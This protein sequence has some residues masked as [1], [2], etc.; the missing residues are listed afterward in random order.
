MDI[1]LQ[2]IS[3]LVSIA[4]LSLGGFVSKIAFGY[5]KSMLLDTILYIFAIILL[6]NASFDNV[7]FG[8]F[9]YFIVGFLTILTIR[10]ITTLFGLV[11]KRIKDEESIKI[12]ESR[13]LNLIKNLERS[14]MKKKDI[15][16]ILTKSGFDEKEV[17]FYSNE[18][19][20]LKD[21]L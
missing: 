15:E 7:Y 13:L 12:E 11:S 21:R 2:L 6:S 19:S 10:A 14:G 18:F 17:K 9:V 4:G 1:L 16:K 3:A 8:L 20:R 5:S